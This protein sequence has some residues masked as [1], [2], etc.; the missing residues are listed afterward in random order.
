MTRKQSDNLYGRR[1]RQARESYGFKQRELGVAAGLD[2]SA[3]G[4]TVSRY[5]NGVHQ[6]KPGLQK[7]FAQVLELPL[8]FFFTEDEEEARLI[9]E[10]ERSNKPARTLIETKKI[11]AQ[12]KRL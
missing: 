9:A 3:A 6:A 2:Y 5:E 1:L 7:R 11:I 4:T 12:M 8:S 10:S